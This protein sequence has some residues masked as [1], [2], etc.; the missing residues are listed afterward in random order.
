[1]LVSSSQNL[2]YKLLC[3]DTLC[4][5]NVSST[6]RTPGAAAAK[7]ENKKRDVYSELPFQYTFCPFAVETLGTFGEEALKL[8][9][10]ISDDDSEF[11]LQTA[12][13]HHGLFNEFVWR[14]N[15]EILRVFCQPCPQPL[16]LVKYTLS[17]LCSCR[18]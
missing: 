5:S 1:M 8:I 11:L 14:F 12:G 10:M 4:K 13:R 7:S 6:S 16:A 17:K 15:E 9:H 18:N 2:N 3:T